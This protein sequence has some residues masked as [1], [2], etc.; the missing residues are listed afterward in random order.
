MRP[1]GA[2]QEARKHADLVYDVGLHKGEDTAFYLAKGFRVVAFEADPELASFCRTRFADAIR[3]HR[4]TIVEGA[5]VARDPDA[6]AG[7]RKVR[8]FRNKD[9]SVWG[10]TQPDWSQR[11]VD[12]R[13]RVETIEVDAVDFS[14]CLRTYGVPYF[15][16]IDIEGVDV[17]CLREQLDVDARPDYLSI[18]SEKVS[19]ARLQEEMDLLAALGYT[20]FQAVQQWDAHR[21]VEPNPAR[22]GVY[23]GH[24]FE[25]GCSGLFGKDLPGTWRTKEEVLR[26]YRRIFWLYRLFGD[27]SPLCDS[28]IARGLG[29]A[30][31]RPMPGWY[32]TH[33]RHACADR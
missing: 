11:N 10:T 12:S 28:V 29:K 33:A 26:Q 20:A 3:G 22:E 2:A 4:L 19:F 16:K 25:R 32:D 9:V 15:M 30:L 24:A 21:Q 17:V 5:I 23:A 8:F 31:G 27:R 13:T 18:E 1:M 6:A 14:R 7:T